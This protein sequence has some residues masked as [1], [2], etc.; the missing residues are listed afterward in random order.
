MLICHKRVASN[1]AAVLQACHVSD[2]HAT[3]QPHR[4][5][6]SCQRRERLCAAESIIQFYLPL[7]VSQTPSL[8]NNASPPPALVTQLSYPWKLYACR[9][10]NYY[11]LYIFF[12]FLLY[13]F[14]I[15][16]NC[17]IQNNSYCLHRQ[18]FSI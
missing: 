6:L 2:V 4:Q 15:V 5:C 3:M 11:F 14:G 17:I 16:L 1:E 18:Y 7:L 12:Y 13:V 8:G 10:N 9:A